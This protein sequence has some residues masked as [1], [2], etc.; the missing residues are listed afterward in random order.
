MDDNHWLE[1]DRR[2][3][4]WACHALADPAVSV[5]RVS[6]AADTLLNDLELYDDPRQGHG[7]WLFPDEHKAADDLATKLHTV[8]NDE[9]LESW[10]RAL[11]AHS[12]WQGICSDAQ[13]LL[14]AIRRNG[15][16][17]AG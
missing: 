8:I 14:H 10:G 6:E 11:I 17:S 7:R 13:H 15:Q 12:L 1:P 9:P 4:Y 5:E 3:L 2:D 16:L